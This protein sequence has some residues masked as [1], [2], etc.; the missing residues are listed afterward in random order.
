[1]Q[2]NSI[3]QYTRNTLYCTPP[4][5]VEPLVGSSISSSSTHLLPEGVVLLAEAHAR[6]PLHGAGEVPRGGTEAK[7]RGLHAA[8][9]GGLPG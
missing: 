3:A 8:A 6:Q 9:V 5:Q 4:I 2:C 1:M 7:P